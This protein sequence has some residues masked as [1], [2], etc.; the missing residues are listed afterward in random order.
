MASPS[1]QPLRLRPAALARVVNDGF[2]LLDLGGERGARLLR[3][4]PAGSLGRSRGRD[5]AA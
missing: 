4:P 1:R 5:S 3:Y 2:W